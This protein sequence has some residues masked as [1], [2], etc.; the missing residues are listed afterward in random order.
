MGKQKRKDTHGSDGHLQVK[1]KQQNLVSYIISMESVQSQPQKTAYNSENDK[2][3]C[4]NRSKWLNLTGKRTYQNLKI[5]SD[6][7]RHKIAVTSIKCIDL[8]DGLTIDR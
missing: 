2:I 8:S 7:G 4:W 3:G 6:V 1:F 5:R